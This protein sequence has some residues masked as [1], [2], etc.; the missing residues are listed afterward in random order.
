MISVMRETVS[1]RRLAL[2]LVL[3]AAT[4]AACTAPWVTRPEVVTPSQP[5]AAQTPTQ[6]PVAIATRTPRPTSTEPPPATISASAVDTAAP[7][8]L[9]GTLS[10]AGPWL[11]IT[12]ES[13]DSQWSLWALNP[14]GSG[15]TQLVDGA[16]VIY[17]AIWSV[18]PSPRNGLVTFVDET[19]LNVPRL[20]LLSL[21]DRTVTTL[22][23]LMPPGFDWGPLDEEGYQAA[24]QTYAAVTRSAGAWSRDGER[25]A[26]VGAMDGPSSDLYLYSAVTGEFTRLTDGPTET[27]SPVWSPDE[28]YV[29]H[30]SATDLNYGASGAGYPMTGMWA[31]RPDGSG[32]HLVYPLDFHGFERVLDWI[33]NTAF[34]V[35]RW[36]F[37]IG[38]TNLRTADIETGQVRTVWA[39]G[40]F[41]RAY[42]PGSRTVLFDVPFPDGDIRCDEAGEPGVYLLALGGGS[43]RPVPGV[44]PNCTYSGVS[45]SEAAGLFFVETESGVIPVTAEGKILE[46]GIALGS[47]PA[48]AP[49][50]TLWAVSG[51]GLQIGTPED[52]FRALA[53][54][55]AAPIWRP[56]GE[57]LFLFRRQGTSDGGY[58]LYIAQSPE[59]APRL[60]AED[61]QLESWTATWIQP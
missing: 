3:L 7:P 59:F 14:D 41:E 39:R 15:L 30:G 32:A 9:A 1:K 24:M 26:F 19:E 35:D 10:E 44:E 45:W 11:L 51:D 5:S 57:A 21:R 48:I 13:S 12:T 28:R 20:R 6:A 4:L 42:D 27:V 8:S 2:A 23:S 16:I 60:V 53:D 40:Y 29:L 38:Y 52:G 22:T 25:L 56:D 17:G 49:D 46:P 61:L 58:D 47:T 34:L 36:E 55:T 33:S 43:P 18:S 50:G 54:W 37:P 31:A